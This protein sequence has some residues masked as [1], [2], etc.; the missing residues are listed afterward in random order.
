LPSIVLT[1]MFWML[2]MSGKLPPALA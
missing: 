2:D 1:G